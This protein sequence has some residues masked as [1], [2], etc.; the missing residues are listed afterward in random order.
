[1]K[2]NEFLY[3]FSCIGAFAAALHFR[4]AVTE[5]MLT[6]GTRCVLVII[7]SL[8]LFSVLSA[9]CIR[10]GLLNAAACPIHRLCRKFLRTDGIF[11]LIW[12]F[13]QFAGYP[14]GVQL[15]A[16]LQER[17]HLPQAQ[18]DRL[19]CCCFGCGPA[20]L[21]GLICKNTEVP[22][23]IPLIMMLSIILPNFLLAL[24]LLRGCTVSQSR[25]VRVLSTDFTSAVESGA[26][27]M[28]KICAMILLFSAVTAIFGELFRSV[29]EYAAAMTGIAPMRLQACCGAILEISSLPEFLASGGSLPE[30]AALLSF[31]GI[32]VHLQNAAICGGNF[33]WRRF[34]VT[35]CCCA[36]ASYLL[37][38]TALCFCEIPMQTVFLSTHDYTAA[39]TQDSVLPLLCTALM[40]FVVLERAGN[41][42]FTGKLERIHRIITY[43]ARNH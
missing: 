27:A 9:F 14:V 34:F 23:I 11:L 29:G 28:M 21:L 25:Q 31:G 32:C 39:L 15:L 10:T 36:A 6:A 35:R 24:W 3:I 2:R 1:M 4:A 16:Q 17:E 37:C 30:A 33:P 12:L 18:C 22:Q 40:A 43:S 38:R 8:Y 5:A 19:L 26:A 13:S 41:P 42:L 7:P 20:F